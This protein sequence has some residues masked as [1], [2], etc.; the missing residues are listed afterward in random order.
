MPARSQADLSSEDF[1]T[2]RKQHRFARA[3]PEFQ[4]R[5]EEREIVRRDTLGGGGCDFFGG[6]FGGERDEGLEAARRTISGVLR[7]HKCVLAARPLQ[8][9]EHE[10]CGP[11][12]ES[13]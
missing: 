5:V 9:S 7:R 11:K 13:A 1:G 2:T 3:P 10:I 6:L 8:A 4:S 12:Q